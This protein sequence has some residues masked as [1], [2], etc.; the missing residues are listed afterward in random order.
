MVIQPVLYLIQVSLGVDVHDGGDGVTR[1]DRSIFLLYTSQYRIGMNMD[2]EQI[3][4]ELVPTIIYIARR[5]PLPCM[6]CPG[7]AI[8]VPLYSNNDIIQAACHGRNAMY[9]IYVCM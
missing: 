5:R 9:A 6:P 1:T 2:V 7:P 4:M 3:W 8:T